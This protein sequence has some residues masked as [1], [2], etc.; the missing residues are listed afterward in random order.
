MLSV[1]FRQEMTKMVEKRFGEY[2]RV[3]PKR[4]KMAFN[5]HEV[6]INAKYDQDLLQEHLPLTQGVATGDQNLVKTLGE[7]IPKS[8]V[9]ALKSTEF[10]GVFGRVLHLPG[11]RGGTCLQYVYV[12]DYQA[13]P[14][15]EADYEPIFV[16][17]GGRR[18]HA[19]YDLV[20]YCARRLELGHSKTDGPGLRMIPGWHSFLPAPQLRPSNADSSLEVKP[21][22]DQHLDAWYSIPD[23]STR[24]K[25]RKYMANPFLLE[26]PG[27][28]LESPDEN[29]KTMCCTFLEIESALNEY[30]DPRKGVVEGVK[31]ALTKCVGILGIYRLGALIQLLFE[32]NQI[33]LLRLGQSIGDS[34]NLERLTALLQEGLIS[35]TDMGKKLIQGLGE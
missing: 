11:P 33:G 31:R 1:P 13:V 30:D 18:R 4:H 3:K 20:H 26:T 27:H 10:I 23:E 9:E 29:S 22:S 17:L 14:A 28:F 16:Y 2:L 24:F 25:I 12:Y 21:L 6:G 15:H 19:V 7:V 34:I 35:L 8:T 5:N 32:M